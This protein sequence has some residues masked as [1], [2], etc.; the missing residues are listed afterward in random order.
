MGYG[1]G[2]SMFLSTSIF[3]KMKHDDLIFLFG[4]LVIIALV[5]V[6]IEHGYI[7]TLALFF[8]GHKAG[9]ILDDKFRDRIESPPDV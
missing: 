4:A 5:L 9:S 6:H 1:A 2:N 8:G 7:E 3:Q